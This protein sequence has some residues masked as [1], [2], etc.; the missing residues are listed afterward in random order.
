MHV[1]IQMNW[2]QTIQKYSMRIVINFVQT[3]LIIVNVNSQCNSH[4]DR[5]F[6]YNK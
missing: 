5:S 4:T 1:T 2:M 3:Y 6:N